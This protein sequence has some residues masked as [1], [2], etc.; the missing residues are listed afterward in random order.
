M[1]VAWFRLPRIESDD[2]SYAGFYIANGNLLIVLDRPDA[3]QMGYIF[4]KGGYSQLK[5]QGIERLQ[6]N[7]S[8]TIPWM[9]DRV[10][11]LGSFNDVHM[12]NIKS[13]RLDTWYK[14]GLLFIGDA[15]HVMSPVGG[16]GINFAVA[17]AVET[18]NVL[19][20]P[21]K[22]G[23]VTTGHLAEVQNRRFKATKI[24]QRIQNT[25]ANNL[26][27]RAMNNADFELP[28]IAKLL[29]SIPFLRD[30]PARMIAFGPRR[31]RIENP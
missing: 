31:V 17:D 7:I 13:D 27:K 5:Q 18:A 24:M 19:T 4:P 23:S 12:L 1:D 30:I 20:T 8:A 2:E 15:A 9:D 22:E 6:A 14:D 28:M 29:L 10:E 21:L 25:L 26:I 3:W 16:V 11:Q